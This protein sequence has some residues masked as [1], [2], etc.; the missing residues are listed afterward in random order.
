MSADTEKGIDPTDQEY[1]ILSIE[2]SDPPGDIEDGRWYRYV[3]G[4]GE[5]TISGYQRGSRKAVLNSVQEIVAR[6][7]ER[8]FGKRGRVHLD[9]SAKK[10]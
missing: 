6:V 10:K 5:T 2:P 8:R 7:N 9:M 4:F 1:E 3:I